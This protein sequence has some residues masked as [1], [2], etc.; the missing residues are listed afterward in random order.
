VEIPPM[1]IDQ[2]KNTVEM[3]TVPKTIYSFNVILIKLQ[4]TFFTD[5]KNQLKISDET[6][7]HSK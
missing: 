6:I 2:Q 5:I 3:V 4:M 7:K 1:V